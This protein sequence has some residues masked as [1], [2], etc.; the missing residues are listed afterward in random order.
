MCSC[1]GALRVLFCDWWRLLSWC[2]FP[3]MTVVE[4]CVLAMGLVFAECAW[5]SL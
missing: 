2:T 4:L 3:L 5:V 1:G